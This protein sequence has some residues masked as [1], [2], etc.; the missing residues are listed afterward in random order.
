MQRDD[1]LK[2]AEQEAAEAQ[3]AAEQLAERV[4]QGDP[5]VTPQQLAAQQQL[6]DFAKLRVEAAKRRAD[7]LQEDERIA[8]ADAARTAAEHL[9]GEDGSADIVA[10]TKA[11]ADAVAELR[12]VV[13]A[14]NARVAEVGRSL[15]R[16]DGDLQQ[17]LGI[18]GVFPSRGRY[19]VWGDASV[20]VVQGLGRVDQLS[21]GEVAAAALIVGLGEDNTGQWNRAYGLIGGLAGQ[22]VK[23]V[24]ERVPGL[25]DAWRHTPEAYAA[26]PTA[27]R[28]QA[29]VQGRIPLSA[30]Q[31]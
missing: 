7:R 16:L 5:D 31:G 8:L 13:D 2:A 17:H 18:T 12:R 28:Y 6:A 10:A 14:R 20:V 27:D 22:A 3:Q 24:G 21:A 1:T 29:M 4:R 30:E 19:G 15:A 11:A 26:L 25:A 9:L 23:V